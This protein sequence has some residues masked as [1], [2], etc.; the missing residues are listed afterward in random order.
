[1]NATLKPMSLNIDSSL[2]GE[3]NVVSRKLQI[4]MPLRTGNSS[5]Q[6]SRDEEKHDT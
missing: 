5:E 3:F 4:N 6:D 1:M 2:F